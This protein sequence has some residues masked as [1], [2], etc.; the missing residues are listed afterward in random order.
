VRTSGVLNGVAPR[1]D[2]YAGGVPG[3]DVAA[4]VF[5]E[6]PINKGVF[7]DIE[8]N[9]EGKGEAEISVSVALKGIVVTRIADE[10]T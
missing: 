5:G 8:G 9:V 1:E 2:T 3:E 6:A 7:F 4:G 10:I